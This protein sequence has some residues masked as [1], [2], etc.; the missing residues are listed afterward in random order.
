MAHMLRM[1]RCLTSWD[2]WDQV[3]VEGKILEERVEGEV[4]DRG[5][6]VVR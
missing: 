5:K 6:F 2:K 3:A 4:G 1:N